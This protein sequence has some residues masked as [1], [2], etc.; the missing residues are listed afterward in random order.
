MQSRKLSA[1]TEQSGVGGRAVSY[2][3]ILSVFQVDRVVSHAKNGED[4]IDE[5]K[6]A[7][8]P[9]ETVSGR[10]EVEINE[11]SGEHVAWGTAWHS[12]SHP[13]PPLPPSR[14]SPASCQTF[15]PGTRGEADPG[16]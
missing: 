5:G 6:D 4:K 11:H 9:Q 10:E 13:K 16:C 8:Q 14:T 3:L 2:L 15:T 1:S 7:V 12:A